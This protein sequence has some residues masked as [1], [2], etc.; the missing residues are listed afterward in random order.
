MDKTGVSSCRIE[1][2]TNL[3][4]W[5]NANLG[6]DK[7]LKPL[8]STVGTIPAANV[9]A[10]EWN[11]TVGQGAALFERLRQ[12]PVK[13]GEIAH[14]FVG[15]QTSADTVFLFKDTPKLSKEHTKVY[16]K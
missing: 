1:K 3:T 14:I 13:L 9:S 16:S 10:A 12:M 11:F 5:S 4:A 2:V 7:G 6:L 8:V 15:L